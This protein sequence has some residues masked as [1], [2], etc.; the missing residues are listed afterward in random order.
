MASG[1]DVQSIAVVTIRFLYS[2]LVGKLAFNT[3]EIV[4]TQYG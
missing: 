2:E 4:T 1:C 3:G